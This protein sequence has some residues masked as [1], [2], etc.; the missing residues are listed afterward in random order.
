MLMNQIKVANPARKPLLENSIVFES[1]FTTSPWTHPASNSLL[2]G[3]YPH[4]H[5]ARHRG[6]Y[7]RTVRDPWPSPLSESS[8]TIFTHLKSAGYYTLGISTIFWA[9]N[10][11]CTYTGCDKIIRSEK[12]DLSYRNIKAEWVMK[13][14]EDIFKNEIRQ[15]SFFAYLHLSDLHRPFDLQLALDNSIE[16]IQLLKGIEEWHLEPYLHEP[17]NIT[18]FKANKIKLYNALIS[19]VLKQIDRLVEFLD[20]QDMLS[21]TTIII[22]ADHGE[23]FWDH[24]EFQKEHY[25]CGYRSQ[26]QW[27]IG[28]GHGHTLFNE[29]THIPLLLINPGFSMQDSDAQLPVSL[30]DIYPTILEIAGIEVEQLPDGVNL[31]TPSC[32]R[33]ILIESTLYGYEKKAVVRG[34]QKYIYSPYEDHFAAYDLASDPSEECADMTTENPAVRSHLDYIFM[35]E[36]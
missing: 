9:L 3:L 4:N 1:A 36:G 12:Q 23:E 29:L 6:R 27:L 8:S 35:N 20:R 33:E 7:R 28:T 25:D 30:V 31:K 2:T 26:K 10:E 34:S 17:D 18:C 16:P 5:G 13:V 22:T 11:K 15:K 24:E 21:N 14:F 32:Q 19:Y